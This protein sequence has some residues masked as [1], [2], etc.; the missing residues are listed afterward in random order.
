[1][2]NKRIRPWQTQNVNKFDY[3]LIVPFSV[4]FYIW[5]VML[6]LTI[7]YDTFTVPFTLALKYDL[8]GVWLAF[9]AFAILVYFVDIFMRSRLAITKQLELCLDRNI[10]L[11]QYVNSWLILDVLSC[12]PIEYIMMPF[13]SQQLLD[14]TRY[15]RLLRLLKFGRF[16][17]LTRLI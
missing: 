3:F 15:L 12:L 17:E 14:Y 16:Y 8:E 2:I 7:F 6:T 1:M 11:Q 5:N 9:D 10:V 4:I 13:S